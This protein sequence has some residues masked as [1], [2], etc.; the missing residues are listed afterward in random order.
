MRQVILN[1]KSLGDHSGMSVS[2]FQIF[3]GFSGI[4][5]GFI[6]DYYGIIPG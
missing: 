2:T 4:I 5:P 6:G 3:S 1:L